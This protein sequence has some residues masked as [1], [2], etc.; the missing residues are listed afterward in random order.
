MASRIES[1][2][3]IFA[4]VSVRMMV[5]VGAYATIEASLETRGLM[6]LVIASASIWSRGTRRV[7]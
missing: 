4:S 2:R 1:R 5:L 3:R 7:T 6:V